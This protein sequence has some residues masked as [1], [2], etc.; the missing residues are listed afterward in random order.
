MHSSPPFPISLMSRPWHAMMIHC[1]NCHHQFNFRP[2]WSKTRKSELIVSLFEFLKSIPTSIYYIGLIFGPMD[3]LI[4]HLV[5][6]IQ[7]GK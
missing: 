7:E 2:I 1:S 5:F 6:Q 4:L 3:I